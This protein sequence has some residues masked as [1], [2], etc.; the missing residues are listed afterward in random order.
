MAKKICDVK[1]TKAS[2]ATRKK[3]VIHSFMDSKP[4]FCD[5]VL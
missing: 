4:T 3:G 2:D 5:V 1:K